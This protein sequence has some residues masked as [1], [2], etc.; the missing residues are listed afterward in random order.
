M[1]AGHVVSASTW[2]MAARSCADL[3]RDRWIQS[4][5]CNP[6]HHRTRLSPVGPKTSKAELSPG[7]KDAMLSRCRVGLECRTGEQPPCAR[8]VLRRMTEMRAC[9][10][11]TQYPRACCARRPTAGCYRSPGASAFNRPLNQASPSLSLPLS[12]PLHFTH[13]HIPLFFSFFS[14]VILF[15][16]VSLYSPSS[17]SSPSPPL[18]PPP[19]PHPPHPPY[20]PLFLLLHLVLL[21]L[22]FIPSLRHVTLSY[23]RPARCPPRSDGQRACSCLSDNK[24]RAICRGHCGHVTVWSRGMILAS[25][26]KGPGFNSRNSPIGFC[27]HGGLS[28]SSA[29]GW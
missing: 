15:F 10:T 1:I 26:A 11:C 18:L 17:P 9:A 12:L 27:L 8:A 23:N 20:P 4:P 6:L 28:V 29:A 2:P 7:E 3:N 5:W 16:S 21:L 25:G 24:A 14:V 13:P 19:F 22:F